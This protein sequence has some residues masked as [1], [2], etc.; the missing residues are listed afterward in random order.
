MPFCV[1]LWSS[2]S[3]YALRIP[4]FFGHYIIYKN[5][6]NRPFSIL[7]FFLFSSFG[8]QKP[9][10]CLHLGL[11][12]ASSSLTLHN[13]TFFITAVNFL[14]ALLASYNLCV[15]QPWVFIVSSIHFSKSCHSRQYGEKHLSWS[16]CPQLSL[17]INLEQSLPSLKFTKHELN[18]FFGE[19]VGSVRITG[20]PGRYSIM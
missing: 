8:R 1:V 7:F 6:S 11:F 20:I 4:A 18:S 19:K 17:Y 3:K 13:F 10:V 2:F 12:S 9:V 16:L 14:F 5:E 15:L